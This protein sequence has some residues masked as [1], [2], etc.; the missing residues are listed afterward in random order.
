MIT[1]YS[2]HCPKCHVLEMKL[3]K[4]GIDFNL[5]EDTDKLIEMGFKSAPILQVGDRYMDF[6]EANGY[7]NSL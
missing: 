6:A 7:I 4:K 3:R 1:L 5:V 2:T